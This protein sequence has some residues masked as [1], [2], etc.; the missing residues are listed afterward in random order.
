MKTLQL[1]FVL[2]K[3]LKSSTYKKQFIH[4][5]IQ[6]QQQLKTSKLFQLSI[7]MEA[8]RVFDFNN[9]TAVEVIQTIDDYLYK[10]RRSIKYDSMNNP[11]DVMVIDAI[12]LLFE[13]TIPKIKTQ[14]DKLINIVHA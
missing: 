6:T 1:S 2:G 12:P 8:N 5:F 10:Y 13:P 7:Y 9:M 14:L 4:K 3:T 11:L